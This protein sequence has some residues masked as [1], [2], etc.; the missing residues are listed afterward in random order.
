[1]MRERMARPSAA[2]SPALRRGLTLMELIVAIVVVS[3]ITA[4][5][6]GVVGRSLASAERSE[7]RERA[8]ARA[9]LA[10]SRV[11]LDLVS[12]VRD[13]DLYFVKLSIESGVI[14]DEAADTLTFFGM[15]QSQ[16]RYEATGFG[17]GALSEGAEYEVAFRLA[18][19]EGAPGGRDPRMRPGDAGVLWRRLDPVP[20]EAWDGG[21]VVL[22]V[23]D[24]IESVSFGAFDGSEWSDNWDSDD[25]G[26]PYAVRVEVVARAQGRLDRPP[27]RMTARR[28]VAF[29]RVPSPFVTIPPDD[30]LEEANEAA[31][32]AAEAGG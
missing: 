26:I 3:V 22:P 19:V 10:A 24:G 27:V 25:Q 8:L 15:P 12:L 4:A 30:R 21:G 13:G 18:G 23:A 28:V 17:S 11:A 14:G 9:D 20:D 31:A 29:D 1:M 16:A 7:L 5:T 32:A 2:R 6:T